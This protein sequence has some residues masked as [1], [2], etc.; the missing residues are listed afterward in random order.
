VFVVRDAQADADAVRGEIVEAIRGHCVTPKGLLRGA[1]RPGL[2]PRVYKP[3][4]AW[5]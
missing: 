2:K 1:S 3:I 4:L 5:R